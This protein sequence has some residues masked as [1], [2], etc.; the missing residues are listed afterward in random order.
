M[1]YLTGEL[2]PV[3]KE[4]TGFD[5]PVTGSLPDELD[6]RYLRIGP[7]PIN[8]DPATYHWFLGDG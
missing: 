4:V 3:S 6:G 2:G 8:P 1:I 7:N 5:L